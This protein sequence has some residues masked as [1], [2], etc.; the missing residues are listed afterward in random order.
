MLNGPAA[1]EERDSGQ[2][3]PR[4]QANEK[5]RNHDVVGDVIVKNNCDRQANYEKDQIGKNWKNGG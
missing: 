1:S 2:D 5:R 4:A 3:H